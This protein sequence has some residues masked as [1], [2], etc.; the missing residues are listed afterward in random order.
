MNTG[1]K[2][3]VGVML[4]CTLALAW[5][6]WAL[7]STSMALTVRTAQAL[8]KAMQS[9]S[10]TPPASASATPEVSASSVKKATPS[11]KAKA[12]AS[13]SAEPTVE[14]TPGQ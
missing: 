12:T 4:A 13:A 9:A 8:H 14:A 2:V 7:N 11:P 6:M 3:T 1:S 10:P 5:W